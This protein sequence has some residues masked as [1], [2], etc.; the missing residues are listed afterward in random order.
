MWFQKRGIV[1]S[2]RESNCIVVT[3]DG[4]YE[5][6]PLPSREVQVG[7]EVVYNRVPIPIEL[8]PVL[9]AA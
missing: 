1:T 7:E 3:P 6:V 4:T 8:K 9:M 2:I 5:K